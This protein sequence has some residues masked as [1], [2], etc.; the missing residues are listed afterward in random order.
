[1]PFVV[2]QVRFGSVTF[3]NIIP[4]HISQFR[5]FAYYFLL[6]PDRATRKVALC[7]AC[8][9]LSIDMHIDFLWSP[10]GLKRT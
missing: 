5:S 4:G 10:S 3:L 7:S 8:Q 2:F 9:D 1:M 6:K